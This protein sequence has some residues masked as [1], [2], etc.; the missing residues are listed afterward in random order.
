MVGRMENEDAFSVDGSEIGFIFVHACS[1]MA[2]RFQGMVESEKRTRWRDPDCD[3]PKQH[4]IPNT[5]NR[6]VER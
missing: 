1:A 3:M 4:R 2:R 6:H 5:H